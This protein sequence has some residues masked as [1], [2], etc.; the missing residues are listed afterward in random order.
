MRTRNGNSVRNALDHKGLITSHI[1]SKAV[2]TTRGKVTID[3]GKPVQKINEAP[4][5]VKKSQSQLIKDVIEQFGFP[6]EYIPYNNPRKR[7][8]CWG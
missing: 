3:A 4:D 2:L 1:A 5:V 6:R 7:T 8:G